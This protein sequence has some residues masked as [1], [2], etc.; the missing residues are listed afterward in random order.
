MST[1]K[2]LQFNQWLLILLKM[3]ENKEKVEISWLNKDSKYILHYNIDLFESGFET[4]AEAQTRLDEL[5]NELKLFREEG[6]ELFRKLNRHETKA[7]ID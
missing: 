4:V 2:R 6:K 1:K 3:E 5:Q 7:C